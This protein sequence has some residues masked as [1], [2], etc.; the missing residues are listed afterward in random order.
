MLRSLKIENFR[1]FQNFELQELGQVN[2]LVGTNNSGKTSVLDA[3][4]ILMSSFDLETLKQVMAGRGEYVWDA[5]SKRE[6]DIRH[7]FYG[8]TLQI[9]HKLL[10]TSDNGTDSGFIELFIEEI[11]LKQGN[12]F[13]N[14]EDFKELALMIKRSNQNE[15]LK[16]SLSAKQGL[17]YL[18]PSVRSARRDFRDPESNAKVQYVTSSALT[19]QTMISLFDQLILTPEEDLVI[20]SLR[21]I[22][23][24]IKRIAPSPDGSRFG[25]R[26]GF[27]VQFSGH[28]QR[29][30]IGSLGDG[31]WRMLG[32][33]L[34]LV[35]ARGGILLIDEIDTGL[36]FTVMA[37]LWKLIWETAKRLDVQVFATTHN[38]DCWT[39]LATIA[40]LENPSRE[41]ITIHRIE[42]DKPHS[43]L[44][45]EREIAIAANRGIEVR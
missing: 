18:Y 11:D 30:P 38:S 7:L 1:C 32:L 9:N 27:W 19:P 8:H 31:I 41:G 2:L 42:K 21:T 14:P 29:V 6:F 22:E 37:D 24:T 5:G 13:E 28:D 4:K 36:H 25:D 26:C 15:S 12:R 17:A 44:F 3:V 43:I 23:P 20:E 39:S 35:N 16:L 10:I 34:A 33:T 40:N 45:T